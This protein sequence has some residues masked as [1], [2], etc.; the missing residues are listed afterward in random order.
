MDLSASDGIVN[1]IIV[2]SLESKHVADDDTNDES[3]MKKPRIELEKWQQP[4]QTGSD[5][6]YCDLGCNEGDLIMAMAES[7]TK[8]TSNNDANDVCGNESTDEVSLP[9]KPC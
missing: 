5:I 8:F 3:R 2:A 7:L 9:N 1:K 4:P 6:Y